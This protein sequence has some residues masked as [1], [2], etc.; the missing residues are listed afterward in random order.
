MANSEDPDQTIPLGTILSGSAMFDPK[1]PVSSFFKVL[2]AKVCILY[3]SAP[4]TLKNDDTGPCG[5][6]Y[7]GW[8][9]LRIT[10]VMDRL[11]QTQMIRFNDAKEKV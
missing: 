4:K 2:G 5:L 11:G 10:M 8:L 3:T 6:T 9:K 7:L 1:G